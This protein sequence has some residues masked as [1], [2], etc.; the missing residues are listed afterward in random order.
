MIS[1]M[2]NRQLSIGVAILI[3]LSLS[4][5]TALAA[6]GLPPPDDV[7]PQSEPVFV[8][9]RSEDPRVRLDRVLERKMTEPVCLTPCGRALDRRDIYVIA[10]DGMPRTWR[11]ALPADRKQVTL[12]V[13]PGSNTQAVVGAALAVMGSLAVGVGYLTI[14]GDGDHTNPRQDENVVPLL[15]LLGGLEMMGLG[16]LLLVDSRTHVFMDPPSASGEG[17]R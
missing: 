4:R 5:G 10:G 11:F 12:R 2:G 7:T 17:S 14:P 13:R 3:A 9:L 16:A 8:D 1:G 6:D 15:V